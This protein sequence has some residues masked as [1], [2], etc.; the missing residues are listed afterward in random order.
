M[1]TSKKLARTEQAR[2]LG[3]RA[4]LHLEVFPSKVLGLYR[5][6]VYDWFDRKPLFVSGTDSSLDDAKAEAGRVRCDLQNTL[7]PE[8]RSL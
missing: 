3:A 2:Y 1:T 6:A 8:A 7:F 4:L 5:C